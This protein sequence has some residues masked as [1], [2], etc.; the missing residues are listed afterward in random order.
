MKENERR[1][2]PKR[3][4][5]LDYINFKEIYI[6]SGYAGE[7]SY[8]STIFLSFKMYAFQ[9]SRQAKRMEVTVCQL[10]H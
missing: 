3:Y 6:S 9:D 4:N 5:L 10:L 7:V 1:K 8:V 2:R